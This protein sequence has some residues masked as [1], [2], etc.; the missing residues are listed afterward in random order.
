MR[1]P[2]RSWDRTSAHDNEGFGIP[3][4]EA[5]S[6]RKDQQINPSGQ[7][8][9]VKTNT[10]KQSSRDILSPP[11]KLDQSEIIVGSNWL[12]VSIQKANKTYCVI[13][14]PRGSDAL[15][16]AQ[17]KSFPVFWQMLQQE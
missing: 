13:V 17:S 10:I 4:V 12:F 9:M 8:I 7:D 14:S 1:C 5:M 11:F 16:S 3:I 15:M 6:S 2:V